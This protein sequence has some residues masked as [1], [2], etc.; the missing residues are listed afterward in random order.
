MS[1]LA[2]WVMLME[3]RKMCLVCLRQNNMGTRFSSEGKKGTWRDWNRE[4]SLDKWHKPEKIYSQNINTP[5]SEKLDLLREE[6][7]AGLKKPPNRQNTKKK[8]HCQSLIPFQEDQAPVIWTTA[9]L[10]SCCIMVQQG[11]IVKC[12][13]NE[14]SKSQFSSSPV[15]IPELPLFFLILSS[16]NHG[17]DKE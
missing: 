17:S 12:S 15:S 13:S 9:V 2:A 8:K 14:R 16:Y 4:L 1:S 5:S 11:C 6:G 10:P 7:F 3:S